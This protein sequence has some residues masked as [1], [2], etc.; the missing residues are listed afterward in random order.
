VNHGH[1]LRGDG[2]E[3]FGGT[4]DLNGNHMV[5]VQSITAPPDPAILAGPLMVGGNLDLAVR[6]RHP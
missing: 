1:Y 3:A 2:S 6:I 4:P 5:E